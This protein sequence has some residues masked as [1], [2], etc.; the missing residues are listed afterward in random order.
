MLVFLTIISNTI[1]A[2]QIYTKNDLGYQATFSTLT[3]LEA[4]LESLDGYTPG[5]TPV[6][7]EGSLSN[8][9]FFNA[10]RTGFPPDHDQLPY[11]GG[12]Y[13][14]YAVGLDSQ[15][16]LYTN[17]QIKQYYEFILGCPINIISAQEALLEDSGYSA[18][19]MPAFP[20]NG[21]VVMKDGVVVARLS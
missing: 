18:I 16:S 14:N 15:V 3:R 2:N 9:S 13:S 19:E 5:T 10:I 7:L 11:E 21:S 1:Y 20:L 6:V 17:G 8:N 12:H 4:K